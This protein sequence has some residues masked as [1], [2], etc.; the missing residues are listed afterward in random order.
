MKTNKLGCF[1]E[2]GKEKEKKRNLLVIILNLMNS[3]KY[4]YEK[5]K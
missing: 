1:H 3:S 5:K 4:I 2:F